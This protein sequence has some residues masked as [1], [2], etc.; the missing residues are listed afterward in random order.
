MLSAIYFA[1]RTS[2]SNLH[3][4]IVVKPVLRFLL[5]KKMFVHELNTCLFNT[6]L[7]NHNIFSTEYFTRKI[8]LLLRMLKYYEGVVPD[9][10]LKLND[11]NGSFLLI[12]PQFIKLGP[13][14]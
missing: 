11:I 5:E 2:F 9:D 6:F 1:P 4:R 14:L 3:S 13:D 10:C 8:L 7:V 12:A